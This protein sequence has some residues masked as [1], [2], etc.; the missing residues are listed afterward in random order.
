MADEKLVREGLF[1]KDGEHAQL[2]GGRCKACG[3]VAFPQPSQCLLCRSP[4]VE[5]YALGGEGELF[6][7]TTVHQRAAH[8]EPPFTVGYVRMP[9]GVRVFSQLREIDGVNFEVGMPMRV[10]I[11]SLWRDEGMDVVG[12]RFVPMQKRS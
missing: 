7:F 4:E 6:T 8:F 10:E 9:S 2:L 11:A 1:R 5:T 3:H 12:Y